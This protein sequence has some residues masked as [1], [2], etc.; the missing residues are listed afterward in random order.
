[1]ITDELIGGDTLDFTDSVPEYPASDGWTLKYRLTPRF[2]SPVQA[3]IT[4]T[5]STFE[6]TDYR[7]QV[8]ASQR[9]GRGGV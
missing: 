7:T 3:P 5:A 9:H 8:T 4:I 2:A 6:V 1:M